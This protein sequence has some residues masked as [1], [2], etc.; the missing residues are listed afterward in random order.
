MSN[1]PSSIVIRKKD[2]QQVKQSARE[3]APDMIPDAVDGLDATHSLNF[4][5]QEMEGGMSHFFEFAKEIEEAG[6][7]IN[8]CSPNHWQITGGKF[9]VNYYPF[10]KRG[11]II[12][13]QSTT[14]G[15]PVETTKD[16]IKF[17]NSIPENLPK[18][19]RKCNYTS[20]L[21]WLIRK[22]N[23]CDICLK[24]VTKQ[25]AS[26]DHVIPLSKGG[27]NNRNNYR[28]THKSCNQKKGNSV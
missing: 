8:M 13:I 17:A 4:N 15:I 24:P 10:S 25:E 3:S 23:L 28:L 6:L 21:K 7:K 26:L 12:Y 14:K 22:S 2:T 20:N 5:P 1:C 27:L 9:L 16:V 19:D 18:L 11:K